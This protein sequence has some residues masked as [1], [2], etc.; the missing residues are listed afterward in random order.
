MATGTIKFFSVDKGFGFITPS[1]GSREVF[2]H[3]TDL[4]GE[5]VT[6]GQKVSYDVSTCEPENPTLLKA[7]NVKPI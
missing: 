2:V 3:V 7:V 6:A 5:S 1:D 4:R